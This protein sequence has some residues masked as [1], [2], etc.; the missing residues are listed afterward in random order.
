MLED[1]GH[2]CGSY[3]GALDLEFD[4]LSVGHCAFHHEKE[5]NQ[6][7]SMS[8]HMGKP[9]I[10]ICENKGADQLCSNCEADQRLCFRYTD[11]K[12]PLQVFSLHDLNYI[13]CGT[14][15]I[16][17]ITP[18]IIILLLVRIL[19]DRFIIYEDSCNTNQHCKYCKYSPPT[20]PPP[21]TYT[22]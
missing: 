17:T 8:C 20:Y 22:Q 16:R 2:L 5:Q 7:K 10:C 18:F 11:S 4:G 6:L 3:P 1:T 12:I 15:T 19:S 21:P 13:L 14:Q 9:S